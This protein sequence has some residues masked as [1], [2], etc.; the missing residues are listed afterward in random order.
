[1][2]VKPKRTSFWC[3]D[4]RKA[5]CILPCFRIYHT[6][7]DFKRYGKI[8]REMGDDLVTESVD[9]GNKGD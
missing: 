8:Y 3:E 1:M 4:C 5:P 7:K 2:G 6:E 9:E